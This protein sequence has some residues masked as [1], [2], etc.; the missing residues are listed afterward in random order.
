M[1][2]AWTKFGKIWPHWE[3]RSYAEVSDY[4]LT[5]NGAANHN[6]YYSSKNA[7]IRS[8]SFS[9]N[10]LLRSQCHIWPKIRCVVCSIASIT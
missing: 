6:F 8:N 5:L 7:L 10:G 2:F 4:C 9:L 3:S 1:A